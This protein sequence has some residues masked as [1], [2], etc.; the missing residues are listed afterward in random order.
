MLRTRG[1]MRRIPA[2]RC[3]LAKKS[4]RIVS[5]TF[6]PHRAPIMRRTLP[7]LFALLLAGLY[8]VPHYAR[9]TRAEVEP[10]LTP[11]AVATSSPTATFDPPTR[12]VV[13]L[14]PVVV[15]PEFTAEPQPTGSAEP[16]A[17]A[18][19]T[20]VATSTPTITQS[21]P[22]PTV[23]NTAEQATPGPSPTRAPTFNN[24]QAD[25]SAAT[26]PSFPVAIASINKQT[27]VVTL[28]NVSGEPVNLDGWIMCSITGNQ[29]HPG[30][31]GVL[32][33]QPGETREFPK[34][35]GNIWLNSGEDDGALYNPS[36]VLINYFE[37]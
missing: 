15:V 16:T 30:I 34:T 10:Q 21:L 33:L 26:A 36:E 4:R 22:S 28:Q 17:P 13:V 9:G 18:T 20:S 24:C 3:S 35:G 32:Q 12:Q 31:T 5:L 1:T 19:M 23:T 29:Q 7:I 37:A 11:T 8:L 25:P 27:E 2:A 6:D 14:L